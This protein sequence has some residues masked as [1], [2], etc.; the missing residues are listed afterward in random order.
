MG[1]EKAMKTAGE[2]QL[3]VDAITGRYVKEQLAYRYLLTQDEL[4][5]EQIAHIICSGQASCA[6]PFLNPAS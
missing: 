1:L 6:K 3:L 4:A 2:T 5:A